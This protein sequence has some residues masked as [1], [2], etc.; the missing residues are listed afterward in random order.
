MPLD[1]PLHAE[2]HTLVHAEPTDLFEFLVDPRRLGSH[3]QGSSWMMAG[4]RMT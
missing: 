3:T 2:I 1:L 4:G